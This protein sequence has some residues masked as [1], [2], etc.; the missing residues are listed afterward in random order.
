MTYEIEIEGKETGRNFGIEIN[1][2]DAEDFIEANGD[3]LEDYNAK[4]PNPREWNVEG[5][6]EMVEKYEDRAKA[7]FS[8]RYQSKI[9][10]QEQDY[11]KG[12]AEEGRGSNYEEI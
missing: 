12:V 3:I 11:I 2:Y 1:Q 7:Y 9:E 6:F 5:V 8:N 10:N 4:Y